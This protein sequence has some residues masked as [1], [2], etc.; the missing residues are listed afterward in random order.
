M[1]YGF[2]VIVVLIFVIIILYRFKLDNKHLIWF[3]LFQFFILANKNLNKPFL[4]EWDEQYHAL[5]AKN[6]TKNILKPTL[7]NNPILAYDYKAWNRNHIWLHKPPLTLW[8]MSAS[9]KVFG[10][11]EFAVRLPS[12]V[13]SLSSILLSF[14][15]ILKLFDLKT[16]LIVAYFQSVSG[17]LLELSG[18]IIASD[19]VDTLF[20]FIIEIGVFTF[21]YFQESF[22]KRRIFLEIILIGFI[23][24]LALLTKWLTGYFILMLYGLYMYLIGKQNFLLISL[25]LF[26]SFVISVLVASLWYYFAYTHF[27]QEF[28]WEQLY[29]IKHF[30]QSLEGHSQVWWY[31]IDNARIRWNEIIYLIYLYFIYKTFQYKFQPKHVFMHVWVI[32]PY[33]I[34]SFAQTKMPAYIAITAPAVFYMMAE[35]CL[36]LWNNYSKSKFKSAF[37]VLSALVFVL[38]IRY[39]F[40]RLKPFHS[41]EELSQKKSKILQLE[42]FF[43]KDKPNIIFGN[44]ESVRT[45][46]YLDCI[47]YSNFPSLNEILKLTPNY[48][49]IVLDNDRLSNELRKNRSV[50]LVN[51]KQ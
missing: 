18:G 8:L 30:N 24:A 25:K 48:H 7:Y 35:F 26:I 46:F 22:L 42:K 44:D 15:I 27:K 2:L 12:L 31:Y 1:L 21:L 40:E 6:L 5:V 23:T 4:N 20:V 50:T 29:N 3:I 13:F 37:R 11:T 43:T 49:I 16:A 38:C 19:H 10:N 36:D 28:L 17:F 14:L 33:L 45:M 32:V 39:A 51:L 47:S 9:I 34:F 41:F